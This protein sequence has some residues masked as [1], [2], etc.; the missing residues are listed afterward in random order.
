VLPEDPAVA[1]AVLE[2]SLDGLEEPFEAVVAAGVRG[3]MLGPAVVEAL[4]PAE[5]ASC[6]PLVV[7]LARERLGFRGTLVSDD[8]DASGILRGRTVGEAAVA[9]LGAGVDLLLV[10]AHLAP[11]C[12]D[13]LMRAVSDGRIPEVRLAEAAASVCRLE[14]ETSTGRR[15]ADASSIEG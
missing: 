13:A 9:S 6:S 7:R 14:M 1:P 10:S 8:L 4:D 15:P 12:A 5:A 11:E 2:S 3:I